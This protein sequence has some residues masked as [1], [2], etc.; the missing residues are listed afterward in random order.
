MKTIKKLL[1]RF[2]TC[3]ECGQTNSWDDS[4]CWKCGYT[5]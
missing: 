4:T 5:P 2:W 1:K 3:P